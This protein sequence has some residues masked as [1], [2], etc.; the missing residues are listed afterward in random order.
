MKRL[1]YSV[2]LGISLIGNLSAQELEDRGGKFGNKLKDI[3]VTPFMLNDNRASCSTHIWFDSQL[4]G[5]WRNFYAYSKVSAYAYTKMRYGSATRM[6]GTPYKSSR[7][8]IELFL[9]NYANYPQ[10]R[11]FLNGTDI[12][13]SPKRIANADYLKAEGD[14]SSY[15]RDH[16]KKSGHTIM[17]YH[18][19]DIGSYHTFSTTRAIR[20]K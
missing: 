12:L 10:A 18:E 5:R 7:I 2:L 4:H 19:A 15:G 20:W 14:I 9:T 3:D 13:A 16:V 11:R 1:I 17:S 8:F 6:C